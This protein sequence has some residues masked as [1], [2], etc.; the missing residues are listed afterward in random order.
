MLVKRALWMRRSTR[1]GGEVLDPGLGP[2]QGAGGVGGHL[3]GAELGGEGIVDQQPPRQTV[4]QPKDFLHGFK[5]LDG[6]DD[7][8]RREAVSVFDLI[9]AVSVILK[10]FQERDD[11]R[12]IQADPYTVSEKMAA[13]PTGAIA[14]LNSAQVKSLSTDQLRAMGTQQVAA[15]SK[16]GLGSFGSAQVAAL[17]SAQL[18]AIPTKTFAALSGSQVSAISTSSSVKPVDRCPSNRWPRA[19]I[20]EQAISRR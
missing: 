18:A 11:V 4:A 2:A 7:A 17:D 15:L 13:L 12:E 20:A 16:T 3:D 8:R 10:R 1:V 6:A 5:R 19:D 9:Q 14:A